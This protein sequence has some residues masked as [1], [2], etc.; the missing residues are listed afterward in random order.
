MRGN[1]TPTPS[2]HPYGSLPFI[3]PLT[4]NLKKVCRMPHHLPPATIITF[5]GKMPAFIP[6]S[7]IDIRGEE[8]FRMWGQGNARL[9]EGMAELLQAKKDGYGLDS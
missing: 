9:P 4:T 8:D 1:L 2:K 5:P 3:S 6:L 7:C